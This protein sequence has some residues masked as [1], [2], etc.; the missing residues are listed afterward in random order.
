MNIKDFISHPILTTL[1]ILFM[2]KIFNDTFKN[3]DLS[4]QR[5]WKTT[6]IGLVLLLFKIL[7]IVNPQRAQLLILIIV[8][9]AIVGLYLKRKRDREENYISMG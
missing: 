6:K 4:I 5:I 9:T 8:G 7:L 1:G 3:V 2:R